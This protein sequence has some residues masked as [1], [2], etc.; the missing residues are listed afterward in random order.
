MDQRIAA[1]E[2]YLEEFFA[3]YEFVVQYLLCCSGKFVSSRH[4]INNI[5]LL[6]LRILDRCRVAE[7]S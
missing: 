4:L 3:K 5:L 6:R 1:E 2:F 7:S